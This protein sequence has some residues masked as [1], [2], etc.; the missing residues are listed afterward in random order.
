MKIN[1]E[2]I[3]KSFELGKRIYNNLITLGDA[4]EI[5]KKLNMNENSARD[6]LYIYSH[7]ITG[8]MLKRTH[9][10]SAQKYYLK[11]IYEDEGAEALKK[12]LLSLELHFNYY[13]E[14]SKSTIKNK[15]KIFLEF[16]SLL[17]MK[18]NIIFQE[19]LIQDRKYIEGS[20]K[21]ILINSYERS[22]IARKICIEQNGLKCF[23]CDF[24]FEEFYGEIGKGYIHIH[25]I[26]ELS[27]CHG[28]YELDPIN[29][30]IPVCP[31]CHSMLHKTKPAT[32]YK[33]LRKLIKTKF[34]R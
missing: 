24:N 22:T 3:K 9:N 23:V 18:N 25:H 13:E 14:K 2:M 10:E 34:R 21:Q 5:L 1:D 29:D 8:K 20:T 17:D 28:E 19:E 30:L 4:V 6:Y 7:L 15:R 32:D 31:N 26:K 16:L 33:E 11:R 12:A 27:S